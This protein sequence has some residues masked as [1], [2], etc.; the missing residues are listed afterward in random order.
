[1]EQHLRDIL[2]DPCMN[3]YL[4]SSHKNLE[5]QHH[6]RQHGAKVVI[7]DL[8]YAFSVGRRNS[9]LIASYFD[10]HCVSAA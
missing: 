9:K 2:S 3:T 8:L 4:R 7:D 5:V 6:K 10:N 1:M